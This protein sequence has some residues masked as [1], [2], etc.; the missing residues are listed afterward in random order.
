MASV[1][2]SLPRRRR[3]SGGL[4]GHGS[5]AALVVGLLVLGGLIALGLQSI[6]LRDPGDRA[7]AISERAAQV[8]PGVLV[9]EQSLLDL[10]GTPDR[11]QDEVGGDAVGNDLRVVSVVDGEGFWVGSSDVRRI[12]VE[13]G[14][15]V[16]EDE[17][18]KGLPKVGD[19]VDLLGAIRPAPQDPARTLNLGPRDA[20]QVRDQ[21]VFVN[22]DTYVQGEEPRK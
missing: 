6:D 19:R 21:G 4:G 17:T 16:G 22:A 18:T 7:R 15:D 9:G 10:V 5:P 8:E 11:L 1:A 14:G 20:A 3:R 2:T 12:Y 13:Y